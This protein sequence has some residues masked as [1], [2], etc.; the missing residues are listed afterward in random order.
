MA[1]STL[2]PSK[3]F[4]MLVVGRRGSE[5]REIAVQSRARMAIEKEAGKLA[6][7]GS[8]DLKPRQ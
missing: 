4:A 8:F 2:L 3:L 6:R 5:T 1:T 7:P